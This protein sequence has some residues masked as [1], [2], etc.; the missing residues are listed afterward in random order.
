MRYDVSNMIHR[1]AEAFKTFLGVVG[2]VDDNGDVRAL[3]TTVAGE[4]IIEE[5]APGT[6]SSYTVTLININT[7]YTQVLPAGARSFSMQPRQT[8]TVR[9]AFVTG[10]VAGSVEPYGSMKSGAPYTSPKLL[11]PAALTVYFAAGQPNTDVEI[12]VWS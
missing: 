3:K 7:Q 12:L 8:R 10:K 9:F 4:L 6:P 2:G 1:V 5:T 11:L